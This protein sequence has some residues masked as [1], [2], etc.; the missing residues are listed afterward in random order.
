MSLLLSLLFAAA[1]RIFNRV[2]FHKNAPRQD[3]R[4]SLCR[5]PLRGNTTV[6]RHDP[7]C[8]LSLCCRPESVISRRLD[9]EFRSTIYSINTT[10]SLLVEKSVLNSVFTFSLTESRRLGG[11]QA[12]T[13]SRKRNLF[14]PLSRLMKTL[15]KRKYST[16]GLLTRLNERN[17]V[18]QFIVLDAL[19]TCA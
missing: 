9:L 7:F 5:A 12:V 10:A 15:F 14:A 2:K 18:E 1:V 17:N 6:E 13:S 8:S 11:R 19:G 16:A 3:H 4:A